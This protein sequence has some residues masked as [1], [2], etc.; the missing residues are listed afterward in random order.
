[1]PHTGTAEYYREADVF[2]LPT[3]S[4]GFALT[5]LEAMAHKL[6][7]VCSKHC[8]KVVEHGVN[9]LVLEQV[10]SDAIAEAIRTLMSDRALLSEL[11]RNACLRDEFSI[12]R[13]ALNL[14][15]I[16]Q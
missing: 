5:Q 1:V 3:L 14:A 13:L 10:T 2:I 4:D 11:T 6:P 12:D 7:V 15:S 9:G 8:G 16:A